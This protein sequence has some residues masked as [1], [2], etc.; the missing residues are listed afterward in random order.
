MIV[1][2]CERVSDAAVGSAI[3][4]GACTCTRSRRTAGPVVALT[5]E[6]TAINQ[7][8]FDAKMSDNWS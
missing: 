2:H 6:L 1:C 5:A 3:A 7:C 4:S 8:F